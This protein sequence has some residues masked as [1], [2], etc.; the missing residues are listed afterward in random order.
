MRVF[1]EIL[2]RPVKRFTIQNVFWYKQGYNKIKK[3]V[4]F[5]FEVINNYTGGKRF[6]A[7]YIIYGGEL[8]GLSA[9]DNN[10]RGG[11]NRLFYL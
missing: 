9:L 7:I 2:Y 4:H 3:R 1:F 6:S 10:R 5:R 8:D 11:S